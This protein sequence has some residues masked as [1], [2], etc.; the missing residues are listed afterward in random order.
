MFLIRNLKYKDILDI[1]KLTIE[2]G[3]IICLFGASGS[4][5]S[6]LLKMFNVMLTPDEGEINYKDTAITALDPVQLRKEVVM[7][8]QDPIVFEG[9]V[10]DNLLIGLRFSGKNEVEDQQLIS[11]MKKLHLNKELEE[12]AS[13]L[14]GGEQQRLAFG[15]VVLMDATVYLMDE[16]TSALDQDT[17]TA[18]M[19]YFTEFIK[20]NEKT[21]I[22]VTHSKEIADRYSDRMIY[23]DEIL[24]K[25]GESY[26]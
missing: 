17:E 12:D 19:D 21:A 20:K 1:K 6:T 2:S 13:N 24:T 16:P 10:R 18:V 3:N 23:M 8:G 7:L 14:S 11:L 9:T 26:E 25:A 15:R 4:G 5:K 22:M